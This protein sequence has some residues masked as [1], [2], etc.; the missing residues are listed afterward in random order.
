MPK[1]VVADKN[2]PAGKHEFQLWHESP[3]YLKNVKFTGGATQRQGRA[4]LTIP[5]GGTLDLGE[6]KVPASML[7]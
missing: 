6:I 5:A 3:G 7:K 4:E 1:I 2:V